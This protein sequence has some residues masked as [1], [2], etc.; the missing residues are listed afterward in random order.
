MQLTDRRPIGRTGIEVTVMGFGGAPLGN[1]YAAIPD[2]EARGALSAAWEAG[3]RYFD[4]A[5]L[6]GYGLSEHRFGEIL[7]GQKRD[8]FVLSTKVGRVLRPQRQPAA[9]DDKFVNAGPFEPI[10]DYTKDGARQSIEQ[11]L[12]RLGMSRVDVVFI[13]DIDVYTHGAHEQPEIFRQAM[14]GAYHG[15]RAMKEEGT[16]GAIGLGVNEWEVCEA[17]LDIGDFDCFLLAGRYTLLEQ[18]SLASFLPKCT[19]RGASIILGGPYNSGILVT[20]AVKGAT[21]NY[22]AAPQEILDRVARI[23]TVCQAH[24]VPMPAAALQFP[25]AHPAVASV[26]PGGRTASEVTQNV[27]W[28]T[29][30]IPAALWT[31]LRSEGLLH[32]DAPVPAG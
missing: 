23:Q 19:E 9:S 2:E 11:S 25:L 17:A 18:G 27:A 7:R 30:P 3:V 5:P 15:L 26:I 10:Y 20:G 6:Y 24:D 13:H 1:L 21:Y 16:I 8:D 29:T 12:H 28:M 32:P 4:T 31:D 22:A 14:S